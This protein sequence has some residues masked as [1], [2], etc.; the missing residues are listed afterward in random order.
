MVLKSYKAFK[1][2]LYI[3][4]V[5]LC[6]T[7]YNILY[8]VNWIPFSRNNNCSCAFVNMHATITPWQIQVRHVTYYQPEIVRGVNSKAYFLFETVPFITVAET[9]ALPVT[10]RRQSCNSSVEPR[11][12]ASPLSSH[13][14][15]WH[16][17]WSVRRWTC[18]CVAVRATTRRSLSI[19]WSKQNQSVEL[20]YKGLAA[21]YMCL[22]PR[23]VFRSTPSML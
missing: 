20:S 7:R 6:K 12:G 18:A 23:L 3:R 19:L 1:C 11:G 10:T 21:T 9:V 5:C 22:T 2:R 4:P 13:S 16:Q 15:C 14:A 8:Y 17:R